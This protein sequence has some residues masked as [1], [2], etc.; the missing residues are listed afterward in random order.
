MQIQYSQSIHLLAG[1]LGLANSV[2]SDL[3]SP[4]A[5][6]RPVLLLV[7]NSDKYTSLT[8]DANGNAT[9]V[10]SIAILHYNS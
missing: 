6:G 4:S 7:S 3:N 8:A 1:G 5:C 9:D 10:R 2:D